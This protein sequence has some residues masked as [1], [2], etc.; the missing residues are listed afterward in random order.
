MAVTE[1]EVNSLWPAFWAVEAGILGT[2]SW[3]Y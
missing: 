3:S 2:T 1:L